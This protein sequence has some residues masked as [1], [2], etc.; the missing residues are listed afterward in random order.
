MIIL[1][2]ILAMLILICAVKISNNND[3]IANNCKDEN[4]LANIDNAKKVFR[5]SKVYNYLLIAIYLSVIILLI[6]A[7]TDIDY[8][9]IDFI[10]IDLVNENDV[11]FDFNYFFFPIYLFVIRE[12]LIQVKIGEFLLKYFKTEEPEFDQNIIKNLLYKKAPKT[13]ST[14]LNKQ[15]EIK[16]TTEEKKQEI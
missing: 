4:D 16:S 3:L 5:K 9:I 14:Q 12:I 10:S 8:K 1:F 2:L 15:T 13:K 11:V 6:C 7:Y